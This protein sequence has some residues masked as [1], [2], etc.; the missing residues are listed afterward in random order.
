MKEPNSAN[1]IDDK[2]FFLYIK[3]ALYVVV[4]ILVML[5]IFQNLRLLF[6]EA[7][8]IIIFV[9]ACLILVSLGLY[10]FCR[11]K[12]TIKTALYIILAISL[13]LRLFFVLTI[14][15]PLESDF[16]SLISAAKQLSR[17]DL[18]WLN[19]DYFTR[20]AF[21][22]PFVFYEA[23]LWKLFGSVFVIKLINVFFMLG[24][25]YLIYLISREFV[26]PKA[27]LLPTLLYAIYPAPILLSSV[28]TNQHI[29][30]FFILLAVY[31]LLRTKKSS[32]G[33]LSG[34][35]LCVGN[36]MRPEG[37]VVVISLV[38]Y[39]LMLFIKRFCSNDSKVPLHK[40]KIMLCGIMLVSYFC[41]GGIAGAAFSVS[42]LAPNGIGNN[43]PEW[44]LVLGL[45]P[46][47]GGEYSDENIEI[48]EIEEDALRKEAYRNV[49]MES[50]SQSGKSVISFLYE[51]TEKMWGSYESMY[52][53]LRDLDL[54]H[55]IT[56]LLPN[57]TV[58]R[59]ITI[60]IL[61]DKAIYLGVHMLALSGAALLIKGRGEKRSYF[62]LLYLIWGAN[63]F[64]Y[65]IIEIQTRYRYFIMPILFIL[66]AVFIEHILSI[67]NPSDEVSEKW[68][69]R[70]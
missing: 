29:S 8:A 67:R 33:V 25:N 2:P 43:R 42:G 11:I 16:L 22:I 17:G 20:W 62:D 59:A 38:A 56:S 9:L 70:S 14:H 50:F 5:T 35:S 21:Q 37:V 15:T 46:L 32:G 26:S 57:I 30:L 55:I 27:A 65:L 47:T 51:K 7:T 48:L 10:L 49:I 44:K 39:M 53:S 18:S 6:L 4:S 23:I 12:V 40:S 68:S 60:T 41:F 54:S 31:L 63:Y 58:K 61:F 19:S 66:S 28:L 69:T 52:W 24:T 13:G 64:A 45:N 34:L 1:S 3:R 36:L